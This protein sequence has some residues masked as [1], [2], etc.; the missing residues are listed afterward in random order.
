VRPNA[1]VIPQLAVQQG[2][3]GHLVY[4]VKPDGTAELRPIVVGDY[5]GDKDI[6]VMAGLN[7]GDRVVV[8][9]VLKVA[10]GQPVRIREPGAASAVAAT[11]TK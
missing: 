10:S 4:V 3:N 2:P 11:A 9:G 8:E 7:K 5:Q 6:V 1:I